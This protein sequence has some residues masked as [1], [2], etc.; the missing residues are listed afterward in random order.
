VRANNLEQAR[1]HRRDEIDQIKKMRKAQR[2][3]WELGPLRPKRDVGDQ[4]ES[5]G[6]LNSLRAQGPVLTQT[7]AWEKQIEFAG[8]MGRELIQVGD[9]VAILEGRDRGKI[10]QISHMDF[11]R[12]ECKVE[13]LNMVCLYDYPHTQLQTR[14]NGSLLGRYQSP[15]MDVSKRTRRKQSQDPDRREAHAVLL[16]PPRRQTHKPRYRRARRLRLRESP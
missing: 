14:T 2:E 7:T 1:F 3:D 11:D 12:A 4:K 9:R 8:R 5:W 13:G 10:G 15:R 6:T 16:D